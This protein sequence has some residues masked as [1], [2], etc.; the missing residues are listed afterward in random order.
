MILNEVVSLE[1][2][3][4]HEYEAMKYIQQAPVSRNTLSLS[5]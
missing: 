5:L 3:V 2:T 1:N 4:K